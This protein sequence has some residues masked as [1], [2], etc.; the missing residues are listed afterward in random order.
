MAARYDRT[1][2]LAH[3]VIRQAVLDLFSGTLSGA[4]N[5]DEAFERHLAL[6]FLT[7]TGND[8]WARAREHWCI[9]ADVDPDILRDQI[10]RVLEG[11]REIDIEDRTYRLNG[12]DIARRLWANEKAKHVAFIEEAQKA[13]QKR[14]EARRE[15]LM[16]AKWAEA[17][18]IIDEANHRL[19][20]G[21]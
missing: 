7:A 12:H 2:L 8:D 14:R 18:R 20:F 6:R 16:R 19:R 9:M 13:S 15:A 11:E 1:Q 17:D 3:A 21:T 5:E 4:S 10:V